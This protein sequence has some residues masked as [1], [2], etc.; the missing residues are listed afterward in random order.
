M[1]DLSRSAPA[2][3]APAMPNACDGGRKRRRQIRAAWT[4]AAFAALLVFSEL[5]VVDVA[6]VWSA[7]GLMRLAVPTI[8]IAAGA[9]T[10]GCLWVAARFFRIALKNECDL[11]TPP[12][13]A[14]SATRD[15]AC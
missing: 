11:V 12:P 13:A 8:W 10:L 6:L 4:T 5:L 14:S 9:G 1:I 2:G 7:G 3:E 15:R